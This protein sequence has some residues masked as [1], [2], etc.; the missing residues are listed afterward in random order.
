MAHHSY[1]PIWKIALSLAVHLE[2]AVRCFSRDH[3]YTLGQDLRHG[4]QHLCVRVVQANDATG[5]A[6][7]QALACQTGHYP[8]GCKQ[9][10]LVSLWTPSSPVHQGN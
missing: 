1:L 2:Q 5:A 9:R 4:A 6:R 7:A 8:T 10:T 3:K